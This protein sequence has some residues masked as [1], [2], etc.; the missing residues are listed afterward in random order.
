[1]TTLTFFANGKS[2]EI[3]SG[4]TIAD[5]LAQAG[6]Q[7]MQVVVEYNGQPLARERFAH[8]H[9]AAGDRVEIAQMVGGG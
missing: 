7:T 9:I 1:M 8:T 4:T 6:L 5:M 2:R 3:A